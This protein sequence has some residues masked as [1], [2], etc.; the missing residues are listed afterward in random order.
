MPTNR[1]RQARTTEEL[2]TPAAVDAW[3]A[4]DWST[5]DEELRLKPW[6]CSPAWCGR[7]RKGG[8]PCKPE[9]PHRGCE[10]GQVLRAELE[11]RANADE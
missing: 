7:F 10:R 8:K 4:G 9:E 3:R 5:V 2:I 6:E 1:R 11:C